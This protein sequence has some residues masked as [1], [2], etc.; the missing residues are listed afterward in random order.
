MKKLTCFLCVE[1]SHGNS[2]N[3]HVQQHLHESKRITQGSLSQVTVRHNTYK[4]SH[5][6][7]HSSKQHVKYKVSFNVI[8]FVCP[9]SLI[10]LKHK[11]HSF[12]TFSTSN[13]WNDETWWFNMLNRIADNRISHLVE[14]KTSLD[15]VITYFRCINIWHNL[16]LHSGKYIFYTCMLLLHGLHLE[17]QKDAGNI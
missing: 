17:M 14:T 8:H 15:R 4:Q 6:Q 9:T 13:C 2:G 16:V 11:L 10:S 12:Y 3:G 1:L 5:L 7:G